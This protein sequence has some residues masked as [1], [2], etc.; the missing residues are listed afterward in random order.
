MIMAYL[1]AQWP[2]APTPLPRA[3]R[4]MTWAAAWLLAGTIL[5]A[6]TAPPLAH[7]HV[8]ALGAVLLIGGAPLVALVR[9]ATRA[10][11]DGVPHGSWRAAVIGSWVA[12]LASAAGTLLT[13]L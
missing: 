1:H 4:S 13:S 11:V 7:H 3:E 8:A 9:M 10:Q 6:I 5:A 2:P 12:I